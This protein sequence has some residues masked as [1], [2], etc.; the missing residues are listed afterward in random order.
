VGPTARSVGV[1]RW[2]PVPAC[3]RDPRR[4]PAS[5]TDDALDRIDALAASGVGAPAAHH[6]LHP[7]DV[8]GLLAQVMI[9]RLGPDVSVW[10]EHVDPDRLEVDVGHGH[11]PEL[12]L[13]LAGDETWTVT[14]SRPSG[15][16]VGTSE[17][18]PADVSR[19]LRD[20]LAALDA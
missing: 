5:S 16:L 20:L 9:D 4:V 1:L 18:R 3:R 14:V 8:F 17:G 2:W 13:R 19:A 6:A 15:A 12:V 11:R 10:V 7:A